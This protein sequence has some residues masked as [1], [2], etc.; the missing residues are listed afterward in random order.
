MKEYEEY[1]EFYEEYH[2]AKSKESLRMDILVIQK[3]ADL[4]ISKRIGENFQR[5]NIVEYKSPNDNL[6]VDDYYKVI[7]LKIF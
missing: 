2:L 7:L 6:S 4:H 5:Y 3:L 1:L